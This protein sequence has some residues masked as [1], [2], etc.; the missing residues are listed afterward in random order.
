M[1]RQRNKKRD[2]EEEYLRETSRLGVREEDDA[3]GP[4]PERKGAWETE[5]KNVDRKT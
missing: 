4:E 2:G 3:G 1:A 5:S